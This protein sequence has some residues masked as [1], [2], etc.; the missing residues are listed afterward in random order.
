MEELKVLAIGNSFSEDATC[1][2]HQIAA[3]DGVQ[4]KVV[5]LYIGGCPLERH[6]QNILTGEQAYQYQENGVKLEKYVSI[7]EML[8]AEKWDY[9]TVQ[10]ASPDSGWSDTYEPFLELIVGYIR[11]KAP[12]ARIL[13]HE[14]WAYEI[15][16]THSGFYRYHCNQ[17]EMFERLFKAYHDAA[18]RY[19]LQLIPSGELIQKLRTLPEFD[20][21]N[22]GISLCRDGFH[23]HLLYGRYAV[24][25]MWYGVLT[26]RR[27]KGNSYLP[28][29]ENLPGEEVQK[30][31]LQLIRET[32]D[33]LL[34]QES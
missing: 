5:N 24:A 1:Y 16:S 19:D 9:V 26:G 12:S 34:L 7:E 17:Q 11:E 2:L 20:Y 18:K 22:G 31:K 21:E 28:V 6:W 13:M 23:M 8:G 32:V 33:T 10:Q 3:A 27:L 25:A 15:D 29:T 30:G 4:M 14:T